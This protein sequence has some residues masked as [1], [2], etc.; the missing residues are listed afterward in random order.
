MVL[1]AALDVVKIC[2]ELLNTSMLI[3]VNP[4]GFVVSVKL[5]GRRSL[6]DRLIS[7]P[8]TI[9]TSDNVRIGCVVLRL[10]E[11]ISI[12]TRHLTVGVRRIVLIGQVTLKLYENVSVVIMRLI[13]AANVSDLHGVEDV[14]ANT[15][16]LAHTHLKISRRN[17]SGKRDV[18]IIATFRFSG[19]ST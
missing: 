10:R 15:M 3:V 13:M 6:G 1:S 12:A 7:I 2:R 8:V 16:L 11:N 17:T 4:M 19:G 18:A 9:S 14:R 5:A